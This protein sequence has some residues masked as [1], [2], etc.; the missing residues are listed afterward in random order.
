MEQHPT[1]LP[2]PPRKI[3]EDV[4]VGPQLAPEHLAALKSAGFESIINNGPD[5]GGGSAQPTSAQLEQAA[6]QAGLVYRH[7]PVLP[8]DHSD[9]DACYMVALVAELPHPVFAFCGTG[10]RAEALYQKG[11]QL[12]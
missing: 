9:A 1:P 10:R 4:Y 11:Q 12:A 7:L 8:R 3:N 5:G 2:A 6:R